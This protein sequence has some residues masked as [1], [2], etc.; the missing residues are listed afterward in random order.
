MPIST[1]SSASGARTRIVQGLAVGATAA[2][3][4]QRPATFRTRAAA[5]VGIIPARFASSRFEGKPLA[6]ILGKP[7][8]QVRIIRLML[9]S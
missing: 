9:S 5:A 4:Q 8:I 2:Y 6:P 1:P 7:M 3:L